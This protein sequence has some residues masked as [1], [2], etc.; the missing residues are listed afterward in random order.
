MTEKQE[1]VI[2]KMWYDWILCHPMNDGTFPNKRCE[3]TFK[4]INFIFV[5]NVIY[6]YIK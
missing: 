4:S 5:T 2:Y 3:K 1:Y 6:N